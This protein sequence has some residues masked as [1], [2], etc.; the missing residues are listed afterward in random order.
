MNCIL[1]SVTQSG[2][3][4]GRI[5][6]KLSHCFFCNTYHKRKYILLRSMTSHS[7]L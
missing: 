5:I 3:V 2:N 4:E 7:I 6:I 1:D